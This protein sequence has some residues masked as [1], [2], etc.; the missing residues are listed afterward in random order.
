MCDLIKGRGIDIQMDGIDQ[1]LELRLWE[2]SKLSF[3][4]DLKVVYRRRESFF[5]KQV[6]MDFN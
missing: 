1:I 4:K 6:K 2:Y 5:K 3:D